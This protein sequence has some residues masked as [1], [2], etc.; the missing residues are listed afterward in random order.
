M[1]FTTCGWLLSFHR[2]GGRAGPGHATKCFHSRGI[3]CPKSRGFMIST[4]TKP[5]TAE[6]QLECECHCWRQTPQLWV[7]PKHGDAASTRPVGCSPRVG[8][9]TCVRTAPMRR[10]L[11]SLH[12]ADAGISP[13]LLPFLLRN[14]ARRGV[15]WFFPLSRGFGFHFLRS[16]ALCVR[17]M[18]PRAHLRGEPQRGRG[19]HP[20][21]SIGAQVGD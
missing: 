21:P 20:A 18:Q 15:P 9:Y 10:I 3:L 7:H 16:P 17:W 14:S 19:G 13:A 6:T 2:C 5:L 11:R 12:G 1:L 4:S 8:A